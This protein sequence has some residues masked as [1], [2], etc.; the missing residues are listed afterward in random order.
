M[1]GEYLKLLENLN[2]LK[3]ID[4]ER[5]E[6]QQAITQAATNIFSSFKGKEASFWT[7]AVD[8]IKNKK[9]VSFDDKQH[10]VFTPKSGLE[11][12]KIKSLIDRKLIDQLKVNYT[13]EN[14]VKSFVTEVVDSIINL[15]ENASIFEEDN[16]AKIIKDEVERKKLIV[17]FKRG[18]ARAFIQALMAEITINSS[19]VTPEAMRTLI[20]NIVKAKIS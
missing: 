17:A 16:V 13:D 20:F 2:K 19:K 14:D 5:E 4:E 1:R 3:S 18:F 11:A 12:E 7:K 6:I 10:I 15:V 8:A 9:T